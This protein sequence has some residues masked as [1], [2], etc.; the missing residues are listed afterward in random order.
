[1][2]EVT[3]LP[4]L[5]NIKDQA[6]RQALQAIVDGLRV[7]NGEVGD[8]ANKFLTTKD[9]SAA[10]NDVSGAVV[11]GG[12]RSSQL[13]TVGSSVSQAI[14]AAIKSIAD[15][16]TSSFLYRKLEEGI[17]RINTPEWFL[18]KFGSAIKTEQTLRQNSMEALATQTTTAI[19]NVGN[20]LALTQTQLTAM[21]DLAGATAASVTQLQTQV[22]NVSAVAQEAM[23]ISS[24]LTGEVQGS[25]TVKFDVNGYVVGAGLGLEG[26]GGQYSSNFIV[27][28]DRFAVVSPNG[29]GGVVPFA[30]DANTGLVAIN[31]DLIVSGTITAKKITGM[32]QVFSG[33][34]YCVVNI[35]A[36]QS[37]YI[38]A[39]GGANFLSSGGD[40][41]GIEISINGEGYTAISQRGGYY[42]G[43]ST[44]AS[45]GPIVGPASYVLFLSFGFRS[46]DEGTGSWG[47]SFIHAIAVFQSS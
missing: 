3:P 13:S 4:N 45:F 29:V 37:A 7:R 34:T 30:I 19:T 43:I 10:F 38:L 5:S 16:V 36:G 41:Y 2:P 17:A 27:R 32:V 15:A 42:A 46:G 12:G 18:G 20:N 11:S 31:G 44:G 8:G 35:P 9:L 26:K 21:S 25:W 23:S 6:T 39:S 14:S 47:N 28:A 40:T 1:M 22:G 24:S 33:D